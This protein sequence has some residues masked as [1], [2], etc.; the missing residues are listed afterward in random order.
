MAMVESS[1]DISNR[2]SELSDIARKQLSRMAALCSR[3]EYCTSDMKDKL[4]KKDLS[5]EEV[6]TILQK[7]YKDK[8]LSDK[9]YAIA[10]AREKSALSGWGKNKIMFALKGKKIDST[11][12]ENALTEIDEEKAK[13]KFYGVLKRKWK[14]L[15]KEEDIQQKTIKL[16]KFAMSRGYAYDEVS[17]AIKTLIDK[18]S[19]E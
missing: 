12:I 15:E 13:D 17:D 1:E 9:R 2:T 18:K 8:Y 14:Q 19:I 11:D 16:I 6:E 10:Y 3:K 7:L 4:S 5:S